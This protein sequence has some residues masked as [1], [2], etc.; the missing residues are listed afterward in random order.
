MDQFASAMARE[1]AAL[2]VWCDTTATEQVPFADGVLVLDTAVDRTVRDSAYRER[3]AECDAALA[4]LRRAHPA[5]RTLAAATPDEVAGAGLPEPYHRRALHVAEET[6]RVRAAVAALRRGESIAG[7]L[8]TASHASL[9][10][11]YDCSTPELDWI[12]DHA[13]AQPGV[14]GARLTGAGW[15]GC[16]IAIGPSQAL[17]AAAPALVAAYEARFAR[18]AR[19]W[20]SRAERGVC[21]DVGG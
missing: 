1:G 8:L 3:R 19:A 16:A 2:H 11:L 5:L 17:A 18:T 20:V 15:G 14:T 10:D 7:A 6:C 4:L 21:V 9:R 12:V 13:T